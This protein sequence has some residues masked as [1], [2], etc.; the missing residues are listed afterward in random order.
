M[1]LYYWPTTHFNSFRSLFDML[2]VGTESP[3][4]RNHSDAITN[5]RV[6]QRLR[7]NRKFRIILD[8]DALTERMIETYTTHTKKKLFKKNLYFVFN[9]R[10]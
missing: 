4:T 1:G 6:Q 10:V 9:G 7:Q 5:P 2:C 8:I 3:R